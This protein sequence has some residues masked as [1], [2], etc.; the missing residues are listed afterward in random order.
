MEGLD[1]EIQELIIDMASTGQAPLSEL[2]VSGARE[3]MEQFL[4]SDATVGNIDRV[5]EYLIESGDADIQLRT[6]RPEGSGPFPVLLWF[7][8]GGW[9]VGSID[10]YDDLC[11]ALADELDRLV[12]SVEYRLAPEHPF[13]AAVNDCYTALEWVAA[14]AG[15][16]DGDASR[17]AVGGDSAGGNLAAVTA[18]R[19]R[20]R[21]GP[22]IEQQILAYPATSYPFEPDEETERGY[23]LEQPDV[24]WFWSLYLS[25]D[26]DGKN[27]YA[28]PLEARDLSGLPPA[29]VLTCQYDP[30]HREGAAYA[31]RLVDA[32]VPV[33]HLH[34]DDVPH[35]FLPLLAEPSIERAWEAIDQI[36]D[37]LR[38]DHE[39]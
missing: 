1:S 32:D 13:P 3:Q 24:E 16:I 6:Y 2:S 23:L 4:R 37:E 9:T 38:N 8:G 19:S 30:L 39:Q 27:P 5:T 17:I 26:V 36:G 7:H 12:V 11:R 28:A 21:D 34:Y 29:T 22:G 18:L 31:E 25:D 33:T 15:T 20:D 10:S 35:G 14:N